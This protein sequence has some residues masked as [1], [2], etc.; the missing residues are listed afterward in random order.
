MA[1]ESG[2]CDCCKT[3]LPE[4]R[5][6]N[7]P[8]LDTLA[9][10]L[11]GYGGFQQRMLAQLSRE[12]IEDAPNLLR[13][14]LA[15]MATRRSDDP[16]IALI[17]GWAVVGDV[18]TFYQE[19]L[20]NEGFLRTATERRSIL[21]LASL[22]GYQL[23]PGVAANAHLAF[24]VDDAVGAPG[25]AIVPRGMRVQSV[26][27]QGELPQPFE[28]TETITARVEWN[29]LRPRQM[30]PQELAISSGKLVM[31]GIS[32]GLGGD[33]A[34]VDAS[35]VH[36][37]DL[38]LPLPSGEV[39]TAEVN[40]IYVSGTNSGIKT[41]D[42]VLLVGKQS[43]AGATEQ[44]LPKVVRVVEA[45][46]ALDRT[47]VEFEGPVPKPLGYGIKLNKATAIS[48]QAVSLNASSANAIAGATFSEQALGAFG[49]VQGWGMQSLVSYYLHAFT[50]A[51][52]KATL[53]PAA[54]GAFAMRTR[55]GFFGHNAPALIAGTGNTGMQSQDLASTSIWRNGD[56]D[57]F[58]ERAVSGISDNSWLVLDLKKQLAAFRVTTA[59]DASLA[60][61]GLSGK[62]T[63]LVL[64]AGTTKDEKYKL[65]D[66]TGLVQSERLALAQLPIDAP[67]GKGTAEELQLTL[68]RTVLNLRP[69][70]HL[71]L[72]GER[73][74]LPGVTASEIVTVKE[75]HHSGG[76]TT[77]FFESPGLTLCYLR[78]TVVLNG[79]VAPAT[80][81]E[82][83][84][85][86]LGSGDGA[87]AFQRFTLKRPPLTYTASA[88]EGGVQ[89]S[90]QVRVDRLLWAESAQQI[91]QGPSS[92]SYIVRIA[93]DG[94]A[95]VIF[96]D[97]E[98]GAR[99]PSGAEN[100]VATYRTGTGTPGMV[101]ADRITLMTMRPLGIRGVS[102][103]LAA[104]G[105]ADPESR[106][107]ARA[108]APRTVLAM[109][110]IVS[111]RDAEDFARAF[112]GIG[113]TH[114]VPVWRAGT[115][116]VHVTVA[117]SVPAPV[118]DGAA[119]ALPDYRVDLAAPL[120]RNLTAAIET[121]KE[122]S[123]QLRL[124]TYQPLYFDVGAKVAIDPRYE[125]ADVEPGIRAALI[126]A[127]SFDQRRFAQ[128]VS[129]AEI[130]RV[131]HS[132]AGVL[133]VDLDTLRR[134]DQTS[135]DLPADGVLRAA[136]VQW[137]DEEAEPGS[138]AQLLLINP[139]GIALVQ[140]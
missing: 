132:V 3:G 120:G 128:P 60:Q 30:R 21:E 6:H 99:L 67:I 69:G 95:S 11:S 123:M 8:G 78:D 5:L 113:K 79:N 96:G 36:P 42:V 125:W 92:E 15:R 52:P 48:L 50:L 55:L 14:P 112:A 116:W 44:T 40:T 110:R 35:A 90:L 28:T 23:S 134:F 88:S 71:A 84:V 66:T 24:Q 74:D 137:P 100:V 119:S 140:V 93:D 54:P 38:D 135:P 102:N 45:E 103:P 7:A 121:F 16:A 104:S 130:V 10:R 122:P 139:F 81:G 85:E 2:R 13:Y 12:S 33:A 106:D 127:F 18:L 29:A 62:A 97:G 9:Y 47:R 73:A 20:A 53:P 138:L 49:A 27:A 56:A 118:S 136:D 117:A 76:F 63:G 91:D 17:D 115:R 31:L 19:R 83:V 39:K 41:G 107:S 109:G 129:L 32:V 86:V 61:F 68:E 34:S 124:D 43:A 126:A 58:L 22:I 59:H 46:D 105:A 101:G 133:F 82:T 75:I 26:P 25:S 87:R 57:C 51:A 72:T 37:L 111:L 98:H 65:R 64:N 114:V 94:R 80:H 108:N 131:L 4:P 89:N 1:D 70:Q 77:L